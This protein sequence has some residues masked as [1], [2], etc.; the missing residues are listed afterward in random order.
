VAL[1]HT[2]SLVHDDINDKSKLRCGQ[3]TVNAQWG[4]GLVLLVG[5]FVFVQLLGLLAT[6]SS[7]A[8]R[9]L[10]DCCTSIVEGEALHRRRQAWA[11]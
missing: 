10:G 7:R 5:D 11:D 6:Y 8:I 2:P 4:S 3:V 1:L 9:T